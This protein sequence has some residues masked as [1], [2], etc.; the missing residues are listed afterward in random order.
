MYP[1]PKWRWPMHRV[2][3]SLKYGYSSQKGSSQTNVKP[4]PSHHVQGNTSIQVHQWEHWQFR[5]TQMTNLVKNLLHLHFPPF[6][7]GCVCCANVNWHFFF[8]DE[9]TWCKWHQSKSHLNLDEN[10]AFFLIPKK[11]NPKP[12]LRPPVAPVKGLIWPLVENHLNPISLKWGL[13]R[14]QRVESV[15]YFQIGLT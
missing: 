9:S 15:N 7:T 6:W 5:F 8:M 4:F 11:N 13:L 2:L 14:P 3:H 10:P 1:N 12:Q